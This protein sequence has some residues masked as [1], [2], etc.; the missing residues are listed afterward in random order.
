MANKNIFSALMTAVTASFICTGIFLCSCNASV[1][2]ESAADE[3]LKDVRYAFSGDSSVKLPVIMYHSV[4][5]DPTRTGD[6]VIT[7]QALE[8]DIAYLS[9]NGYTAVSSDDIAAYCLGTSS[10]PEKPVFITFDDGHL[11]NLTYALPILEKYNMKAVVNIV[12]SYTESAVEQNDPNPYYQY[13][14]W[15]QINEI[16]K[17][18]VFEIGAHTYDMHSLS[19]RKGCSKMPQESESE[20]MEAFEADLSKII[21]LLNE[22]CGISPCVFAFPYGFSSEESYPILKKY[23][24]IILLTC[25]EKMNYLS[26]SASGDTPVILDR[27]NRPGDITTAD[28]MSRIGL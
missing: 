20:Y 5:K 11:N 28:F 22:N 24:C 10:L 27:Y 13:L 15:E 16:S 23:G 12:G 6:Y 26:K 4:L 18:G 9:N 1:A 19:S 2:E 14:T 21:T 17:S 7:P 3:D 25:N 8:E